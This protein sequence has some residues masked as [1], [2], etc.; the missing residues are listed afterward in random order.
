[1]EERF[2]SGHYSIIYHAI[3]KKHV[4][5]VKRLREYVPR[6]VSDHT[7]ESPRKIYLLTLL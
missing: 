1:M 6:E 3:W 7:I 5:A 2:G 4:V